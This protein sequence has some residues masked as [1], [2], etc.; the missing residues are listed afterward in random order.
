M[1]Y[2]LSYQWLLL[3][4]TITILYGSFQ[5][6]EASREGGGESHGSPPLNKTLYYL[7]GYRN[8]H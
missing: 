6:G 2:A 5:G 3:T 4:N 1:C 8:Y 7:L